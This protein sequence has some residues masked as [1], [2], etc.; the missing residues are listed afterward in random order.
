MTTS[1]HSPPLRATP[2][3]ILVTGSSG[4]IGRWVVRRLIEEQCKVVGIDMVAPAEPEHLADFVLC[5][6][7]DGEAL[8]RHVRHA[9]P[10]AIIHL[11]ARTDLM[12]TRNLQGYAANIDGVRHLVE[13]VRQTPSVRR[14][15]YA[16]SQLV[17]RVGYVPLRDDDYCPDTLYG[18]SKVLTEQIVHETDGG[19]VEWCIARPTTA[20]GPYMSPH[21]QR[22]LRYI[23]RGRYFHS[24]PGSLFK[25]YV[26]VGNIA[27]QFARLVDADAARVHGRTFYLSDYQPTSLRDYT[28]SL[29]KYLGARPIPTLPLPLARLLARLGDGLNFCGFKRFPFN[30]FRLRNIRTEYVFDVSETEAVCGPLPYDWEGGIAETARWFL[31]QERSASSDP[32]RRAAT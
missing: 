29:A 2:R 23:R 4:F 11:A 20:W 27:Y 24:G 31:A 8:A 28:S 21:Y 5:D 16:S 12:E 17:C 1:S 32:G 15:V 7:R 3:K 13:A 18:Q 14:V 6:I 25:S 10:D 19:G 22:M 26:Y 9:A 30:S